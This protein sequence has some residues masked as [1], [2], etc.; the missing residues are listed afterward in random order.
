MKFILL[1]PPI[2]SLNIWIF[3]VLFTLTKVP[4][5][6]ISVS[7]STDSIGSHIYFVHGYGGNE[8]QFFDMITYLNNSD[9]FNNE[10][11]RTIVPLFFNFYEKYYNLGMTKTQIHNIQGGISTFG[12]DFFYQLSQTHESAE[13]SIVA[14]SLGGLIVR[15][16]L[17]NHQRE[18][19]LSN[20]TIIRVITLGTPHL[21]IKIVDHPLRKQFSWFFSD[22][23]KT[24]VAQSVTSSSPF[25]NKINQDPVKYMKGIDWYFV[26][27]VSLNPL[28]LLAQETIFNGVPRD[29]IVD[30][31]SVLAIGLNLVQINRVILQKDHEQL[32]CDPYKQESYKYIKKWL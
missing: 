14:H 31:K 25:L 13:I 32:I 2:L 6:Q 12:L 22:N 19:E 21:G 23:R 3:L 7:C 5:S 17:F 20:N 4:F 9:L 1:I 15:E 30:C 27:G 8:S 11:N 18:L 26:A 28:I 29:G 16:M 10:V 24:L